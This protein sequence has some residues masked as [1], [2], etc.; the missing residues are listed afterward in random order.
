MKNYY[1][2][3]LLSIITLMVSFAGFAQLPDP[4]DGDGGGGDP[5]APLN[6]QLIW[7]ALVGISFAYYVIS[8]KKKKV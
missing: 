5:P 1:K 4:G 6:T 3:F 2:R 8:L 7:L